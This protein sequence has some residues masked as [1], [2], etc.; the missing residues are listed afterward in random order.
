MIGLTFFVVGCVSVARY[1]LM[2]PQ[3]A[4]SLQMQAKLVNKGVIT[5][6]HEASCITQDNN[7]GYDVPDKQKQ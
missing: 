3:T 4:F 6:A 7:L 5:E 1:F 2:I